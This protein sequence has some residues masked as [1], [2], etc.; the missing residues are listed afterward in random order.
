MREA[1]HPKKPAKQ[2][3]AAHGDGVDEMML[4][5]AKQQVTYI[6]VNISMQWF[7]IGNHSEAKNRVFGTCC[8]NTIDN[9]AG[10]KAKTPSAQAASDICSRTSSR[11]IR[12]NWPGPVGVLT[13]G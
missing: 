8:V 5:A 1:D 12:A 11:G 13:I 7:S 4:G 6:H 9:P 10:C 3:E 2:A